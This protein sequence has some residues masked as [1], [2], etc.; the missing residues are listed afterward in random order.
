MAHQSDVPFKK[1][2]GQV[3]ELLEGMS[4]EQ[5]QDLLREAGILD[6]SGKLAARYKAG[7]ATLIRT[8]RA[9]PRLRRKPRT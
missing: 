2:Y 9:V 8:S 1:E 4:A 6:A 5:H 7:G 3:L